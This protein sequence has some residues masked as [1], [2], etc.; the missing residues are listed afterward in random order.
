MR[1]TN[2]CCG[3]HLSEGS[4]AG[5]GTPISLKKALPDRTFQIK[6]LLLDLKLS[7]SI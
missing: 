1:G 3:F 2:L 6:V 4:W 5:D 7:I